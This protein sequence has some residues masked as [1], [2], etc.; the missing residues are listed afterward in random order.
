MDATA[1][2]APVRADD[3]RGRV[4]DDATELATHPVDEIEPLVST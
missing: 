4:V 2:L 3:G 1:M